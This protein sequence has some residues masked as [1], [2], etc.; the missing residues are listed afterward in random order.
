[1]SYWGRGVRA[2]IVD[3]IFALLFDDTLNDKNHL[4]RDSSTNGTAISHNGQAKEEVRHHL[5]W[6]LDLKKQEEKWEVE[7][8]VRELSF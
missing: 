3:C 2:A 4:L 6:I 5:I 1:M 8:H 7:V